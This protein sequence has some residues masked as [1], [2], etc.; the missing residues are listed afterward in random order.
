MLISRNIQKINFLFSFSS[1]VSEQLS[2]GE[3]KQMQ[4]FYSL[5]RYRN[6]MVGRSALKNLLS[7]LDLDSDTSKLKFPNNK[8][9][10]SHCSNLAVAAGLTSEQ[11]SIRGLGIDIEFNRSVSDNHAKFFLSLEERKMIQSDSDRLRLWTIKEALFKSDPNNNDTVLR[12]YKIENPIRLRGKARN[13]MGRLFY[14]FCEK[15]SNNKKVKIKS[16]GWMS[17]AVSYTT[18]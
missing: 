4:K 6:W 12:D 14:Y 17:C 5:P 1:S 7:A 9:S 11:Q 18:A 16:D 3:Q 10:L 15:L 13:N 2:F 8:F